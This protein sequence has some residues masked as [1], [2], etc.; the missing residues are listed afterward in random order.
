MTEKVLRV[1]Q[2]VLSFV[3]CMV[4]I[5]FPL[6]RVT[7]MCVHLTVYPNDLQSSTV[8]EKNLPK[9]FIMLSYVLYFA[10]IKDRI[11]VCFL[12]QGPGR[13][14][15]AADKL[16]PRGGTRL[17]LPPHPVPIRLQVSD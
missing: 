9:H 12:L 13:K 2:V 15:K 11:A 10:T 3:P 5:K 7:V 17:F 4:L 1:L 14:F 6:S 8:G 16:D